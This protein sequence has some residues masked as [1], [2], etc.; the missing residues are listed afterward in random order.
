[1]PLIAADLTLSE[2]WR[3]DPAGI[4]L[5]LTRQASR[6]NAVLHIEGFDASGEPGPVRPF[7]DAIFDYPGIVTVAAATAATAAAAGSQ[8]FLSIEFALPSFETRRSLWS[9]A[10]DDAG[11]AVDAA[12]IA[13]LANQFE[14]SAEQIATAAAGARQR[15]EWNAT[16]TEHNGSLDTAAE[17]TSAAR[18]QNG[19]KLASLTTLVRPVYRWADIVLPDDSIAQLK[20]ICQRV[21]YRHE[22]LD[23]G[24][25]G[26]KLSA[27]KGVAVLFAGPSGT[28]KSM[29]AEVIA[30]EL[31]LNLYRIDLS[32]VVS[33]YIGE[34]EKHLEQIFAAAEHSNN[35]LLFEEAD[36]LFG[37]RSEIHDA[38]DRYANIE[39]SYLLQKME[40]YEGVAILTTNLRGNLDEA[41][42]RRLAVT[43]HFPFPDEAYRLRIWKN[44]WPIQARLDPALD[45]EALA[46]LKLSGGNIKNIALAT[47]FLAAAESSPLC[48]SHLLH[49]VRREYEKAG[50]LLSTAE[51]QATAGLETAEGRPC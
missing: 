47:A 1:M 37:K 11:M 6:D 16:S 7:L 35:V 30:N 17:L 10:I 21:A 29:A 51:L 18:A 36:A 34:T 44:I 12:T 33:K 23:T 26:G 15:L 43:V 5:M 31:G 4:A 22:V 20:E 45:F 13:S 41:F 2:S 9:S 38:H 19:V 14:L 48:M 49:A 27:G 24:G 42:L 46:R 25:F 39:T 50:K 40:Q 32:T 28:G 8:R 3:T